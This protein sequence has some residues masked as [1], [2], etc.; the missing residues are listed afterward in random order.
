MHF[1]ERGHRTCAVHV[2]PCE[3][4]E[5]PKGPSLALERAYLSLGHIWRVVVVT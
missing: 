4:L 2:T 3:A 5:P 1:L